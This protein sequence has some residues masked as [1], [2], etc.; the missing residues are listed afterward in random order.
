MAVHVRLPP[1]SNRPRRRWRAPAAQTRRLHRPILAGCAAASPARGCGRRGADG[2]GG[3]LAAWGATRDA[4]T[5]L[6]FIPVWLVLAKLFG[7]YDR[8]HRSLRHLTVDDL[9]T[10]A[11]WSLAG[12]A[13]MTL[14]FIT[15]N[16]PEFIAD[17]LAILWIFTTTV[18]LVFRGAARSVFRRITPRERTLIVGDGPL[19]DAARRKLH[20]FP[21]IHVELV[22]RPETWTT[23]RTHCLAPRRPRLFGD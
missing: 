18:A 2:R 1:C 11:L 7:L 19:A 5:L 21:E 17:D 3:A 8:D 9:P 16:K 10:L 15:L 13:A 20:L 12:S 14:V 6:F 22:G 4:K 23:S